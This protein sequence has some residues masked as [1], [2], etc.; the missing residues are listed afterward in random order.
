VPDGLLIEPPEGLSGCEA[1]AYWKAVGQYA[2][3][4]TTALWDLAILEHQAMGGEPI[5]TPYGRLI[6]ASYTQYKYSAKVDR[7]QAMLEEQRQLE[8][9]EGTAVITTATAFR[10]I[11]STQL[12]G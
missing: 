10:L 11:E 3:T 1:L 4:Q 9:N 2:K 7:L 12:E 6:T 5:E 8:R